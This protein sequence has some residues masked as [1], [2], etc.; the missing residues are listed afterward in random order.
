MKKLIRIKKT[1]FVAHQC[2]YCD[3]KLGLDARTIDEFPY[4]IYTCPYCGNESRLPED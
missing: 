1:N 3:K 4:L 2:Q